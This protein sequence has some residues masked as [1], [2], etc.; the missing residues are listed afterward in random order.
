MPKRTQ[1]RKMKGRNTK[2]SRKRK[3]QK[4][5][6]MKG[7]T[8]KRKTSA[9]KKRKSLKMRGGDGVDCSS[10]GHFLSQNK[11]NLR[12]L[13]DDIKTVDTEFNTVLKRCSYFHKCMFRV[14]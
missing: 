4:L 10:L 12:N 9:S 3:S 11:D 7:G 5:N 14:S 6:K 1:L 8:K 13:I 2:L